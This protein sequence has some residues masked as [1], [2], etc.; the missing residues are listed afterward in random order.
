M[1]CWGSVISIFVG[2]ALVLIIWG[3]S[4]SMK[5]NSVLIPAPLMPTMPTSFWFYLLSIVS[6]FMLHLAVLLYDSNFKSQSTPPVP[7]EETICPFGCLWINWVNPS[8]VHF[9]IDINQFVPSWWCMY[10]WQINTK[11]GLVHSYWFTVHSLKSWVEP[12]LCM[13]SSANSPEIG[14]SLFEI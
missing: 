13:D 4:F 2:G 9:L 5:F 6:P 10:I 8:E 1:V 3:W 11:Y 7:I 12:V 14:I